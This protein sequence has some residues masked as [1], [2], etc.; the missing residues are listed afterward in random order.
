MLQWKNNQNIME[1]LNE[2]SELS[3][4]ATVVNYFKMVIFKN[5]YEMP[6]SP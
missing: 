4:C 2:G 5:I 3:G 6:F 1:I